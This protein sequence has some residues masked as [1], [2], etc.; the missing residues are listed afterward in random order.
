MEIKTSVTPAR[1]FVRIM[2]RSVMGFVNNNS[3]VPVLFSSENERIVMAGI[4]IIKITGL[5]PKNGLRS[6]VPPS[7]IFVS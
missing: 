6:A 3:I 1:Y 7:R 2:V 4:K 5:I